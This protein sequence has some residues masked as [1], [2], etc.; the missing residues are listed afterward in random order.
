MWSAV[1]YRR[2][3]KQVERDWNRR[4][5]GKEFAEDAD[6]NVDVEAGN[7]VKS[8][9]TASS[10]STLRS[11]SDSRT[12][13]E[14]F[15]HS[16]DQTPIGEKEHQGS[17]QGDRVSEK[18]STADG[19]RSD[20]DNEKIL[21][22]LEGES[23]PLDPCNWSLRSRSINI[24]VLSFLIFAQGWAGA[25]DSMANESISKEFHV[26]AVAENLSQSMYLFGIGSGCLIVGP[27]SETVG[28]NPTY[29][30][31]SLC[32]MFF[33]LGSALVH[34]FGGQVVC[35]YFVG[36]FASATLGI[37]G[38]SVGDQFRAVKR[39]FVFPVIAWANVAAPMMAPVA[40]GWI[41]SD[42]KLGWRWC[43][44]ITLIIS[45]AAFIV[46]FLF[47][48]ETYLP[49][50]LDWKAKHLRRVTGDDRYQSKHAE[51]PSLAKRVKQVLPMSVTFCTT[52]PV[53]VVLGAF[54]VLL[55]I[56]MY[57]FLSGFEYIFKKR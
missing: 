56:L 4:H 49:V 1:Q 57:S 5:N 13:T 29:L 18:S 40:G 8:P 36:L 35:R 9:R 53:I 32:Y 11:V 6:A 19:S 16:S 46:A 3:G 17:N 27:L 37:N 26:S 33:V 42:P 45:A 54:L 2:L 22:E 10:P 44:W 43:E 12:S 34:K 51:I 50:L 41:T 7:R 55:Y 24:A 47:L 28:R 25:A 20:N 38:A 30:V 52:E 39:S 14:R 15:D 31:S 23:D 21:V 48:P